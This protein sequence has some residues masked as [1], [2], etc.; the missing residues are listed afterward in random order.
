M[1]KQYGISFNA[2]RAD[3]KWLRDQLV[4]HPALVQE[5]QW[6]SAAERAET[7]RLLVAAN[8][9]QAGFEASSRTP[10]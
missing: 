7:R 5:V 9:L 6:P 2:L 3:V 8:L 4:A 10:P 1:A